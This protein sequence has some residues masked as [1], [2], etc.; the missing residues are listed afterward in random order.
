MIQ[1]KLN[2]SCFRSLLQQEPIQRRA[3]EV[4]LPYLSHSIT[5][6]ENVQKREV[7]I[8]KV[9]LKRAILFQLIHRK[10]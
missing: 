5:M 9:I 2:V 6:P 7:C 8:M 10:L 1:H 3:V 4:K